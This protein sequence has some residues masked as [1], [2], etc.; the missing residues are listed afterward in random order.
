[1]LLTEQFRENQHFSV[2]FRF[3]TEFGND[4]PMGRSFPGDLDSRDLSREPLFIQDLIEKCSSSYF[5]LN[6]EKY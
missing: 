3:W 5:S 1:M 2:D 6:P 4:R